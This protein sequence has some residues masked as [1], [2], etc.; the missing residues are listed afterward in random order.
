MKKI[1]LVLVLLFVAS[2][3][4]SQDSATSEIRDISIKAGLM[5]EFAFKCGW[6]MRVKQTAECDSFLKLVNN[7]LSND[8]EKFEKLSYDP[9][10]LREIENNEILYRKVIKAKMDIQHLKDVL[11]YHSLFSKANSN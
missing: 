2:V 8:A 9:V 11:S 1:F 6:N 3:A 10:V 7:F 5:S 4:Q